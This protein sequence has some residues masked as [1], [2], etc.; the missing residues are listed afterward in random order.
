MADNNKDE[1]A[2]KADTKAGRRPS[3]AFVPAIARRV[4]QCESAATGE[5]EAPDLSRPQHGEDQPSGSQ[6]SPRIPGVSMTT[7]EFRQDDYDVG[8]A[9]IP[10]I[11]LRHRSASLRSVGTG[12]GMPSLATLERM[13]AA[14]GQHSTSFDSSKLRSEK[15]YDGQCDDLSL[16]P[17]SECSWESSPPGDADVCPEP[18]LKRETI[19]S[20][21]VP[22]HTTMSPPARDTTLS[23][24][25]SVALPDSPVALRAPTPLQRESTQSR[26]GSSP[27][28]SFTASSFQTDQLSA[29]RPLQ[30][31]GADDIDGLHAADE[32][33]S[34]S[35]NFDLV[36]PS[37]D[38]AVYS[39]ERRSELLFSAEHLRVIFSDPVFLH[40][41]TAYVHLY[42]PHSMPLLCYTLDALKAIRAMEY[43][44]QIISQSL[45][46]DGQQHQYY[47][48][49]AFMAAPEL[50]RN[51]SLRQN[52]AAAL[53]ALAQDE[54]PAYITHVWTE[55]VEVSMKRK[56]TGTMPAHL[57]YLNECL[58][59]V[60]CIT[61][62]SRPDNPI[63]FASEG[64]SFPQSPCQPP[65]ATSKVPKMTIRAPGVDTATQSST[66]RHNTVQTTFWGATVGFYKAPRQILIRSSDSETSWHRERSTTR[67][68]LTIE[69]M[70]C[71]S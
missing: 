42:R 52:T 48:L 17:V 66:A 61:D 67:P 22:R 50:T 23:Q 24:D 2:Q 7:R 65:W 64:E 21:N 8:G 56:I 60:F 41:F 18:S 11:P 9:E 51:E 44:N 45:R 57:K 49:A 39:L 31:K 43:T 70:G 29:L 32:E 28:V 59:E 38:V 19:S 40:R 33:S 62:P 12:L 58:A 26:L 25:Q 47:G 69:E 68:S 53:E 3:F 34:D 4:K 13:M 1:A 63:V 37:S 46:F 36:V 10:D 55:I 16:Y 35:N 20:P 71:L 6:A 14:E 27:P 15:K 30:A 54:L 5:K